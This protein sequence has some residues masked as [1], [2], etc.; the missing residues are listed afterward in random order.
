VLSVLSENRKLF[1][2][3]GRLIG[4]KGSIIT[5]AHLRASADEIHARGDVSSQNFFTHPATK[6]G[7]FL[8][9]C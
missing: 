9:D 7:V 5:D 3:F 1:R 6:D 8:G 2:G 4:E